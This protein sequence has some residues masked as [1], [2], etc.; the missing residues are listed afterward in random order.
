M[1]SAWPLSTS[2]ESVTQ[3]S[4][5]AVFE[6]IDSITSLSSYCQIVDF[7]SYLNAL[8]AFTTESRSIFKKKKKKDKNPDQ[9]SYLLL[10]V[11][12]FALKLY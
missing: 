1:T 9:M 3:S 4:K 12:S 6:Q 10:D 8:V 5:A 11:S 2:I 7:Q